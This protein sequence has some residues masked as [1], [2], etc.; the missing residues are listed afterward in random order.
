MVSCVNGKFFLEDTLMRSMTTRL[1]W[2]TFFSALSLVSS[3]APL[4]DGASKST[5][6]RELT[7]TV[8]KSLMVDSPSA[9]KR[10]SVANA[11]LADVRAINPKELLINGRAPGQTS[12]AIWQEDGVRLDYQV[13]VNAQPREPAAPPK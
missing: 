9:I 1:F 2:C 4:Q 6:T 13:T 8:G 5:S 7:I 11:D 3:A 12:L 10:I